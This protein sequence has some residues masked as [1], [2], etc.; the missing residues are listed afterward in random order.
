MKK[1]IRIAIFLA[2]AWTT[3]CEKVIPVDV[4]DVEPMLV[5][6]AVFDAAQERVDVKLSMTKNVFEAGA[7][8]VI[9]DAVIEIEDENGS[10]T[11]LVNQGD[12]SYLLLNYS[13]Q[14][15]SNYTMRVSRGGEQYEASA[16]LPAVVQLDSLSQEWVPAS[17]FGPEG[18]I[19]FMNF[20]DP[21]GPNYYRAVR[22]VNDTL[23]DRLSQ[24][25]IFDDSFSEGNTQT[26]PFFS[27]RHVV[28]DSVAV[29]F[30]SLSEA[31]YRFYSAL[32][33]LAGDG[34]QSAAPANPPSN[35]SNGAIGHF[36][37]WGSDTK[38][39]VIQP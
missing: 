30:R 18:Y 27:T 3:A 16:F 10:V 38:S 31:S 36:G 14:Y 21:I 9:T 8:P 28:G 1:M 37:A 7:N 11:S 4:S 32:F 13:P 19:V 22:T 17:L 24:Q 15:E 34:G 2:L 35:W 6:E 5:I 33:D 23:F 20:T 26:V 39:I 12:G 25:F 29:E